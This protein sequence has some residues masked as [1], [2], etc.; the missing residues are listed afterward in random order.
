MKI[1]AK[2]ES[3][4]ADFIQDL[5]KLFEIVS[6]D[7]EKKIRDDR[8]RTREA[9]DEDLRFLIDQREGRVMHMERADEE[10]SRALN[11]KRTRVEQDEIRQRVEEQRR[12]NTKTVEEEI[13]L[14]EIN[15]QGEEESNDM[16]FEILNNLT[17]KEKEDNVSILLPQKIFSN[18]E[19]V[20]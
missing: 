10:Y 16:D 19:C 15:P 2:A 17:D 13:T 6:D 12:D 8:L 4:R 18:K 20:R 1:H 3:N 14:E 7:W 5:D 9:R 11:K